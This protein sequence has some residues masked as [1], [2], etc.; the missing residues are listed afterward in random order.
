MPELEKIKQSGQAAK[1]G[2]DYVLGGAGASSP[3]WLPT[4]HQASEI[5]GLVTLFGGAVLVLLR[6][7]LAW[8]ELKEACDND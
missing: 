4:L 5:A 1:H 7:R 3:W 2:F 6:I 8:R